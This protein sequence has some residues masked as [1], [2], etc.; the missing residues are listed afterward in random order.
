MSDTNGKFD[1]MTTLFGD[2][3][4]SE[5]DP[6]FTQLKLSTEEPYV[7]TVIDLIKEVA[8]QT[9][10]QTG[11]PLGPEVLMA[12]VRTWTIYAVNQLVEYNTQLRTDVEELFEDY[13]GHLT[14]LK[15]VIAELKSKLEDK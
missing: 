1:L 5:I 8:C 4:P 13:R 7:N 9:A 15:Q 11:I 3:E 6:I 10:E 12:A 2:D 14:E